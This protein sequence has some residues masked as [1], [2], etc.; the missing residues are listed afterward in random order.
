[1]VDV[2]DG[3]VSSSLT[4]LPPPSRGRST[5]RLTRPNANGPSLVFASY[6]DDR[7]S[8]QRERITQQ[9]C[10]SG[11]FTHVHEPFTRADAERLVSSEGCAE[12]VEVLNRPRGGGYWIWKPLVV[13]EMLRSLRDGDVM[14]YADAG[15]SI[16]SQAKDEWWSKVRRLSES[17]PCTST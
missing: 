11:W 7:Y 10:E 4:I 5:Y 8:Y 3:P 12:A 6:G 16:V 17:R 15:C 14:L 1:M 13:R 2:S 9:A